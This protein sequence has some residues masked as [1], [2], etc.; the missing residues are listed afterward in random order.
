[1]TNNRAASNAARSAN[2]VWS[3][4]DS[5]HRQHESRRLGE[6]RC[7][8]L[9]YPA[10]FAVCRN[11][12]ST[13]SRD[14]RSVQP[15]VRLKYIPIRPSASLLEGDD[16]RRQPVIIDDAKLLRQLQLDRLPFVVNACEFPAM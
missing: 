5:C 1:M 11:N 12:D 4:R 15:S 2:R 6:P 10:P 3:K 13:W 16:E 9:S 8:G 7:C 14:S